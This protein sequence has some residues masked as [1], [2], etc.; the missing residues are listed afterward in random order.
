MFGI[1]E[2]LYDD[3]ATNLTYANSE[4]QYTK[5][6]HPCDFDSKQELSFCVPTATSSNRRIL[7]IRKLND[8]NNTND[9]S[10]IKER[11]SESMEPS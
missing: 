9:L 10:P 8:V 5:L 7:K 3:A 2:R 1:P 6:A 11:Q 4:S